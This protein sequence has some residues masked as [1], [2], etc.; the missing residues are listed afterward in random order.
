MSHKICFMVPNKGFALDCMRSTLGLAVENHY[1][2]CAVV[3]ATLDK[4]DDYNS[5]NLDWIRDMEGEVYSNV[6]A[7]CDTNGL[8]PLTIEELGQKLREMSIIVPYGTY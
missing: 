3:D 8:T 5:E 2:Y 4:F 7:N 1:S 6:Q